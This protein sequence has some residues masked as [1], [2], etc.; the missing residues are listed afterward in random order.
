[1]ESSFVNANGTNV[2]YKVIGEAEDPTVLLIMGL[3][4]SHKLWGNDLPNRLMA[5]GYQVIVFDNRDVGESQKFDEHGDPLMWWEGLKWQLGFDINAPYDLGDMAADS[6]GLLDALEIERVHVVGASMGGMIAQVVAARY[7]ERVLSLTS[8][9]STPGFADHLPP[10]GELPLGEQDENMTEEERAAQ[11]ESFGIHL[12]AM[13]RQILAILKSGDRSAEVRT[14]KSPTLVIHG[15]QDTL[16][17]PEHGEATAELIEG[18]KYVVY[19]EMGHNLPETV[20][21]KMVAEMV[22][23][24][25]PAS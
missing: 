20:M 22:D 9:M 12:D 14:I 5:S 17:V 13:P 1:M 2:A 18:S 16:I 24:M 21:P 19:E 6:I 8:I 23:H 10:P 7:P 25:A 3:G 11:L 4:G 15:E